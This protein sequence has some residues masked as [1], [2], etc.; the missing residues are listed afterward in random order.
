MR[1]P[2][3]RHYAKMKPLTKRQTRTIPPMVNDTGITTGKT[4]FIPSI[5]P[6]KDEDVI[7]VDQSTELAVV[8]VASKPL[9][10]L[11]IILSPF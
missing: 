11:S 3:Q 2:Q 9:R 10:A 8:P 5:M 4:S 7:S 6:L 1:E